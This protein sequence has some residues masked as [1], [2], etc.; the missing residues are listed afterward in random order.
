VGAKGAE[1]GGKERQIR[2]PFPPDVQIP[3]IVNPSEKGRRNLTSVTRRFYFTEPAVPLVYI[4]AHVANAPPA[5][6]YP[7]H[8]PRRFVSSSSAAP[9]APPRV[10]IPSVPGCH[11][12]YLDLYCHE[13]ISLH[14]VG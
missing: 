7:R 12:F 14:P 10:S 5:A 3:R 11:W 4:F 8:P 9:T 6:G 1:S 13:P 2:R